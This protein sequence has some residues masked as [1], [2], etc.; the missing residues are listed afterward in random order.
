MFIYNINI[1][2]NDKLIRTRLPGEFY[3][4]GSTCLCTQRL[5]FTSQLD[6]V[7]TKTGSDVFLNMFK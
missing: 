2:I 6:G 3:A 4:F 1:Y 7:N 5:H